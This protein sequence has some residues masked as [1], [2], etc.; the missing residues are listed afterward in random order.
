VVYMVKS[1][2]LVKCAEYISSV[3]GV[4]YMMQCTLYTV[5]VTLY[6]VVGYGC[7]TKGWLQLTTD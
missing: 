7:N 4:V 3:F 1:T 2:L 6:M 5:Q